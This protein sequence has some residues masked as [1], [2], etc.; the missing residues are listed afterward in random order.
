MDFVVMRRDAYMFLTGPR[1]VKAVTYED[2]DALTL[3]GPEVH[4]ERSGCAHFVV[5]D[6]EAAFAL[7][8]ELLDYLPS[9]SSH[10]PPEVTPEDPAPIDLEGV[11][12]DDDRQPYDVCD[13]IRGVVDGGRFLQ[14][15]AD[16]ARNLVVGFARID[17]RTV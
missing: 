8:R 11:V 16:W 17:G 1:V 15:Q 14:V 3:G 6:D 13:V 7:T 10:A 4:A 12:P 9:S 2:V 5:D